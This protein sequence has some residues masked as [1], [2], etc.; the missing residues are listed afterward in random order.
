[1]HPSGYKPDLG[2]C[3]EIHFEK[4]RSIMGDDVNPI[5]CQLANEKWD[6]QLAQE[7]ESNYQQIVELSNSGMKQC[8]IVKKLVVSKGQVS[9][10]VNKAKS[11]GEIT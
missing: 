5:L 10:I 2:A 6:H 4:S 1:R 8:E 9:K 3:F 11:V 7:K